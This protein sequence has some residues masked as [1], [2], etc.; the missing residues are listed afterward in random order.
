MG[1]QL[2]KWRNITKGTLKLAIGVANSRW[3]EMQTF[4][5]RRKEGEEKQK[6]D[7]KRSLDEANRRIR[8]D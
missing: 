6:E 5:Q 7:H 2:T 1:R 3:E 4:K 8:F